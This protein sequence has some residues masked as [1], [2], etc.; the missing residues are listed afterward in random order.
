M[1]YHLVIAMVW[2]LRYIPKKWRRATLVSLH[3]KD[4]PL[5]IDNYRGISIS[6]GDDAQASYDYDHHEA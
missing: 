6:D 1:N 4:D 5:C 3:K 2:E